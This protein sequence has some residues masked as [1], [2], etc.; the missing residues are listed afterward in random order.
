MHNLGRTLSYLANG[1]EKAAMI[2]LI[3]VTQQLTD[4][5]AFFHIW[6]CIVLDDIAWHYIG[7]NGFV[8]MMKIFIFK[9]LIHSR[10]VQYMLTK[11]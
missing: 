9:Q 4:L 6:Y 5:G 10:A 3:N 1:S 7:L 8:S 2:K 11:R